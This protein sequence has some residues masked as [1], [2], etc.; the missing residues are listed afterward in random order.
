MDVY[1]SFLGGTRPLYVEG[2]SL[3]EI[4]LC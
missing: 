4:V 2:Q 1:Q 3:L